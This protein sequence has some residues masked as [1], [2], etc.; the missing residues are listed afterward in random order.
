MVNVDRNN[1]LDG[2]R[3]GFTR[4]KFRAECKLSI[5]F[6]GEYGIDEGGPSREF[7]RLALKAIHESPIFEGEENAKI[8]CPDLPSKFLVCSFSIVLKVP[9]A[10]FNANL[11]P[12][13]KKQ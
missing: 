4:K 7:M 6:S 8:I 12:E 11:I 1:I 10:C 13:L 3:R 5:K 2:A 9:T